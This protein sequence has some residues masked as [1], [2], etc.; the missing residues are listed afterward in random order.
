MTFLTFALYVQKG[1]LHLKVSSELKLAYKIIVWR[2]LCHN[3]FCYKSA[4]FS[5]K[6]RKKTGGKIE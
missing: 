6:E 3:F 4:A 1:I 5:F 2:I